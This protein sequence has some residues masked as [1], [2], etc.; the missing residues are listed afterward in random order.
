M[1]TST[2]NMQ[3][4]LAALIIAVSF[5]LTNPSALFGQEFV[6]YSRGWARF[7]SYSGCG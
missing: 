3:V 6:V 4:N 5:V 7:S 2:S 1:K